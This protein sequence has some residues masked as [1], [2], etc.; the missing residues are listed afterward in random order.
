MEKT[1][2]DRMK[3]NHKIMLPLLVV[4][5]CA[6]AAFGRGE[7]N[8]PLAKRVSAEKLLLVEQ[9]HKASQK[10]RENDRKRMKDL[11]LD[12]KKQD[13]LQHVAEL[14]AN[15]RAYFAAQEQKNLDEKA[16]KERTRRLGR[17]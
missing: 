14:E 9:Y 11:C 8:L 4:L 5:L 1:E 10:C 17:P 15:P 16:M 12:Q 13:F 2:E 3:K 7:E 6:S